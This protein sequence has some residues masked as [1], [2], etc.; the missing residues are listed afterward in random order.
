KS[1]LDPRCGERVVSE[2]NCEAEWLGYE[3]DQNKEICIGKFVSGCSAEIPFEIL[4][5]CQE[6]CEKK[7]ETTCNWCG[8]Y[9]VEYPI[10]ENGCKAA[11]GFFDKQC[12]CPEI[13]PP[14]NLICGRE[15]GKCVSKNINK[16]THDF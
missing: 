12:A 15:N 9:C 6:V 5:E 1:A 10:S 16:E 11:N 8:R 7:E 2:G 3:F 13:V 14:K 4:E